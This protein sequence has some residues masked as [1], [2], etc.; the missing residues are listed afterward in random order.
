MNMNMNKNVADAKTELARVKDEYTQM[1]SDH[2]T[3]MYKSLLNIE[4]T[5]NEFARA[6]EEYEQTESDYKE[7]YRIYTENAKKIR[8]YEK[9]KRDLSNEMKRLEDIIESEKMHSNV[10]WIEGF[11]TLLPEEFVVIVTGMDQ[12]DYR[13]MTVRMTGRKP[14]ENQPRYI[15]LERLVREAIEFKKQY[16]GWILEKM[17]KSGQYDCFPPKSFYL[18]TYKTP[19]G[20][21]M[22]HGGIELLS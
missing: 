4:E 18:F 1:S 3:E 8:E 7:L 22:S 15:D 6:K 2:Y 19:H 16:P 17:T 13:S 9:K 14:D 12:T 5:K 20:H 21:H 10:S 11:D